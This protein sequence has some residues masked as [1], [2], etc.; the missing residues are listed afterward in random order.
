MRLAAAVLLSFA[1]VTAP[2]LAQDTPMVS[3]ILTSEEAKDGWTFAEPE[4][5]LTKSARI[6]GT[7][8]GERADAPQPE[9]AAASDA[10]SN[11]RLS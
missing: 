5:V 3:P 2:A 7:F 10:S 1:A 8:L 11:W 6:I 4:T 9:T